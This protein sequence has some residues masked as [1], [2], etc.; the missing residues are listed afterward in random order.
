MP[1]FTVIGVGSNIEPSKHLPQAFEHLSS[2]LTH[3]QYS[4][5][6]ASPA[7]DFKGNEFYNA[8]VLGYTD[9]AYT[10]L[11]TQLKYIEQLMGHDVHAPKKQNRIID[12]DIYLFD[13]LI[14]EKIPRTDI[15]KYP[16]AAQILCDLQPQGE[17]PTLNKPYHQLA[18]E[19][20]ANQ[21]LT[22]ITL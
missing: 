10:E 9:L 1:Y 11:N 18:D 8:G 13:R 17:H 20:N 16:F 12:L 15:A 3:L 5:I 6:Y 7:F 22:R 4:S 2:L 21:W 19:L 14:N